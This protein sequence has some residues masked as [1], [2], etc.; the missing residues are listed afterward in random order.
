M[1]FRWI[2]CQTTSTS[3]QNR[4]PVFFETFE[5]KFDP[6]SRS[7]IVSPVILLNS[8]NPFSS[9]FPDTILLIHVHFKASKEKVYL[10]QS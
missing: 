6:F 5:V 8:R 3:F 4:L 1:C 10:K 7:V 9:I 2:L